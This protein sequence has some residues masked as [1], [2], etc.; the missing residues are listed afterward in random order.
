VSFQLGCSDA[1]ADAQFSAVLCESPGVAREFIGDHDA[2]FMAD[3]VNNL[4]K[5]A[6]GCLLITP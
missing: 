6:F 2:R 3:A 1:C 5:D 4:S